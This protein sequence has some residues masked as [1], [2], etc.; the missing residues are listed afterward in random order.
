MMNREFGNTRQTNFPHNLK[1]MTV[2]QPLCT[3]SAEN[4][5]KT[6]EVKR[7][8]GAS[9]APSWTQS[10]QSD[11]KKPGGEKGG[12]APPTE[13]VPARTLE[14][15]TVG[16]TP[17]RREQKRALLAPWPLVCVCFSARPLS[18][19]LPPSKNRK[20]GTL[21]RPGLAFLAFPLEI[22]AAI[23]SESF[24]CVTDSHVT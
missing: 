16:P 15:P 1:S 11:G 17:N 3:W 22:C 8:E 4:V 19:R 24:C 2:T 5:R 7:K 14:T 23:S 20:E 10:F 12:I 6:D 21:L 13:R 18:A 9:V